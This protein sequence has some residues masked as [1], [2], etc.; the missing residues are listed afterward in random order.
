MRS[1]PASVSRLQP[2]F[3]HLPIYQHPSLTV[4]VD[5]SDTFLRSLSFQLDPALASMSFHDARCALDWL[6]L[7]GH[8]T[9]R[10]NDRLAASFDT[11]PRSQEQCNVAFDIAH[12]HRIGFEPQR[13]MTPSVVVVDYSM[14]QM[15][16]VDFC[17]ALSGLSCKKILF[18]GAAD[19]KI[20]VDAFN[21]GL[22]HRYIRKNDDNALD[23]LEAE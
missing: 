2:D 20:A 10:K 7:F 12:I 1:T 18:T 13:F 22:I 16:G 23:K 15:N 11:Y 21:R 14:P 5:D 19:E 17:Q 8:R 9:G 3:M 6:L 4:L